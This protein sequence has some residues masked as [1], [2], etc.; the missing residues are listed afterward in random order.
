MVEIMIGRLLE[1]WDQNL[2]SVKNAA[3]W[4]RHQV[5]QVIQIAPAVEITIGHLF[6]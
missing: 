3:L 1:M 5:R 6:N 2:T 4:F